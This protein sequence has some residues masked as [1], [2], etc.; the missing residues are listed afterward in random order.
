MK[1]ALLLICMLVASVATMF[2]QSE[3]TRY[4]VFE[5]GEDGS[6]YY[7]IP[8]LVQA[9]DGSLV[10]IADKRGSDLGDLPNIISVVAKRSTD[11]G[12]TWSDMVTIAQG[13]KAA[14]NTYGDA[15]A[16]L[17]EE[18]GKIIAVFVGNENYGSNTVG[19]WASNSSYPLRLYQSE[20][21]D[22]GVTWKVN[23]TALSL[24]EDFEGRDEAFT[25]TTAYQSLT[26]KVFSP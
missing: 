4:P 22:N 2:A 23:D 7:R 14:G 8:A 12:K 5:M 6:Q 11:G 18:T 21:S 10:A 13:D 24:P 20:S 19:L 1:K 17:D 26:I 15:A 16:V 9:A 3:L 25:A